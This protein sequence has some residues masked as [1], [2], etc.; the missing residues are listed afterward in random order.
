[1]LLRLHHQQTAA[2][3]PQ[4]N[5]Q[6]EVCNKTIAKYLNSFVDKSTLDWEQY[7]APLMFSYNTS[8]H[9]SVKNT[10]FFL[11]YGIEP[12]LPSFP[13][14]DLRER[15]YGESSAAEM[16]QRLQFARQTAV[17]NNLDSTGKYS[18]Y[19]NKSAKPHSFVI[20]QMVLLE[21]Y[22]FLGR[23][24]NLSP[25]FSGPH[26][27]LSLKGMHNAEILMNTK[28]KVIVNVQRLKPFNS[29]PS[30]LSPAVSLEVPP[31]ASSAPS[32]L[33]V[34]S[35][36]PPPLVLSPHSSDFNGPSE[37]S[38]P[39]TVLEPP[40]P[41]LGAPRRRGRPKGSPLPHPPSLSQNDRGIC[42]RSKTLQEKI[43]KENKL[44]A[45]VQISPGENVTS[46]GKNSICFHK[47]CSQNTHSRS[48]ITKVK[49][50]VSEGDIYKN[51]KAFF[52]TN[53]ESDSED[54]HEINILEEN[55]FEENKEENN[56]S[57]GGSSPIPSVHH[58]F[59]ENKT[60]TH[61]VEDKFSQ[62]EDEEVDRTEDENF[63]SVLSELGKLNETIDNSEK[64]ELSKSQKFKQA[65]QALQET[66]RL[67]K[68]CDDL[69]PKISPNL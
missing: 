19:F 28:R 57:L 42:T 36:Q 29:P 59:D 11:T 2:H 67:K 37:L 66:K 62:D 9:R 38:L 27:I 16:F 53:T 54:E 35:K 44:K 10:P 21:E 24:Q 52:E 55:E 69:L 8:F 46:L 65:G 58:S 14:P 51:Q 68:K 18:E 17:E 33:S 20:N 41:L 60:L 7:I 22:N 30:P 13:N 56:F 49:N 39:L 64:E 12:R 4:C 1:L 50:L 63:L 48:C 15:F 40:A 61:D 32:S 43:R 45:N 5:S 25:K 26:I 23:N 3:H 6:A 47:K 34:P 31:G